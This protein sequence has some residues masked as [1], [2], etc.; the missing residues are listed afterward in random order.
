MKDLRGAGSTTSQ[1][2]YEIQTSPRIRKAHGK[3]QSST[4]TWRS[5]K[6]NPLAKRNFV[7][8]TNVL[9]AFKLLDAILFETGDLTF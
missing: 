4:Y 6:V 2:P 9:K 5:Q 1:H 3:V 8:S 7:V